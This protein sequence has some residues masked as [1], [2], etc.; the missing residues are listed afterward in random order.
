MRELVCG[1]VGWRGFMCVG[2]CALVGR[3]VCGL[4]C[5]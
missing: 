4:E 2:V 3:V 1:L 5:V